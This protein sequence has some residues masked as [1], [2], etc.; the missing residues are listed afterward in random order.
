MA[1]IFS[2]SNTQVIIDEII[3][4]LKCNF[5]H[6]FSFEKYFINYIKVSTLHTKEETFRDNLNYDWMIVPTICIT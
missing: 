6:P 5:F 1:L 2:I 4:K 3:Y